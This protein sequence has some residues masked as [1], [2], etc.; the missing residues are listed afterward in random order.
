MNAEVR[1]EGLSK[2]E[3]EPWGGRGGKAQSV[4]WHEGAVY[5]RVRREIKVGKHS[6]L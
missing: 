4:G 3:P 6:K 2:D 5:L 1:M